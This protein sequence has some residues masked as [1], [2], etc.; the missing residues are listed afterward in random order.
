MAGT[1]PVEVL[2]GATNAFV[3]G[4]FDRHLRGRD[5]GF[6]QA[7]Y[8]Q[9]AGWVAP[10]DTSAVRDWWLAKPAAERA[11]LQRRIDQMKAALPS[12][13][14]QRLGLKAQ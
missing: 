8:A 10:H 12:A 11:A 1:A 7:Q 3:V 6:P 14:L 13:G 9:Y 5:N 2:I 4:F